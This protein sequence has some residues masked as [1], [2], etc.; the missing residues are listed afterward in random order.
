M[1]PLKDL[2]PKGLYWRTYLIFVLPVALMQLI[3][4]GVFVDAHWR[5]ASKRMTQSVAGEIAVLVRLYEQQPGPA[6]LAAVRSLGTEA[7]NL[8][9]RFEPGQKL[10]APRCLPLRS[11]VDEYVQAFLAPA[12][13]RPIWYDGSCRGEIAFF[14]APTA[15]GVLAFEVRKA[16]IQAGSILPFLLWTFAVTAALSTVSLLFIRNQVK[17]VQLLADAMDRF[18]R[19]APLGEFRPRGAR[20]VR[21]A[22]TAFLDMRERLTRHLEQR[23]LLLA[24]VSHDLR[25]PLT[26]LRLHLAL[27]GE[28][29]DAAAAAKDL[30]ALEQT[31]EEYLAFARGQWLESPVPL[32]LAR[33][34]REAAEHA[35]LEGQS[36]ELALDQ[37]LPVYGR[38]N[39]LRRCLGNLVENALAHGRHV[40]IRALAQGGHAVIEVEDDGPGL[41]PEAY[42]EAFRPFSRLDETRTRNLKGVGLGLAIARD[43]ARA[44]GGEIVLSRSSLGGLGAALQIP[45]AAADA[46]AGQAE[47]P[48]QGG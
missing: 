32:D 47:L 24:G 37:A 13:E 46:S 42:E 40:R 23:A 25:T 6:G 11:V 29:E 9:V 17:P 18:G 3:L 16:Q 1:R 2:L 5:A 44:H 39:A 26:R 7:L 33:I 48:A 8:G 21:Q 20:E 14:R 43:V 15:G 34:A 19:G 27:L 4:V 45:L 41:A 36:L 10:E 22:A 28:R 35:P 38:T 31:L 30:E 12:L